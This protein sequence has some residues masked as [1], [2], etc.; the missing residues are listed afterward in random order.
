MKLS[1]VLSSMLAVVLLL[2]TLHSPKAKAAVDPTAVLI[3]ATIAVYAIIALGGT[4]AIAGTI[5]TVKK[6]A[7]KEVLLIEAQEDAVAFIANGGEAPSTLL[8][9]IFSELRQRLA[10]EMS[11]EELVRFTDMILAEMILRDLTIDM[12]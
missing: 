3:S 6:V 9:M 4:A 2:A 12:L 10:L 11:S 1:R 8:Q 5:W 7:S